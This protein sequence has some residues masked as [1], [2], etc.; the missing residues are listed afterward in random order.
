[1]NY[2]DRILELLD[3]YI[4]RNKKLRNLYNENIMKKDLYEEL[5]P[6][7]NSSYDEIIDNKLII[8]MLLN[9]IYNNN[10][11]SKFYEILIRLDVSEDNTQYQ[12]F[13]AMINKDYKEI[14]D[15]INKQI[16][17]IERSKSTI[18][19]ANR[20]RLALKQNLPITDSNYDITGVK[21]ILNY[22]EI[23][24][25]IST[26]E[27]ILFIN[28]IELYNRRLLSEKGSKMEREVTEVI[29]QKIPNIVN[30]G[31]EVY[32]EIKVSY[33]RKNTLDNFVNQIMGFIESLDMNEIVSSIEVY[34]KY[35]ITEDE[36]KYI[37]TCILNRYVNEMIDYYTFITDKEYYTSRNKRLEVV[38][39]YYKIQNIYL[40]IRDYYNKL[41]EEI[42][43]V[44]DLNQELEQ[45]SNINL[46][47]TK[48]LVY[49]SSMHGIKPRILSDMKDVPYEYYDEVWNLL[50]RFKNGT[51]SKEEFKHLQN[52]ANLKGFTE[53]RSDQIR[54]VLKH[55]K[56]DIYS[57]NGVF[58][59]KDNNDMVTY[60]A[61]SKRQ[62][63]DISTDEKLEHELLVAEYTEGELKKMVTEKARKGNR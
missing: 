62:L 56:N 31:Q 26:K 49:S 51:V 38:D 58:I 29:Y 53:L 25:E 35:D 7:I 42:V 4:E 5:L 30:S 48:K 8:A 17:R 19:S 11:Y 16:R 44:Q 52:N 12:S 40:I 59:K 63:P 47:E 22:F 6:L 1:M 9:T 36:Y 28:E 3:I 61:I 21:R 10:I 14:L 32:P 37:I 27:E 13:M 54:I 24:G 20:V 50:D 60:T 43:V 34:K 57:V 41:N 55:I 15:K 2:K 46:E 33:E 39:E 45:E 23:E 18:S